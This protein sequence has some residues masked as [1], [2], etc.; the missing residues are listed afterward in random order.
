VG[1]VGFRSRFAKQAAPFLEPGEHIQAVFATGVRNDWGQVVYFPAFVVTDRAI[2]EIDR[3]LLTGRLTKVVKR[4]ARNIR[5]GP[6]SP[7]REFWLDH[8]KYQVPKACVKDVAAADAAL[9]EEVALDPQGPAGQPPQP[10]PPRQFS[11]HKYF[12]LNVGISLTL[13]FAVMTMLSPILDRHPSFERVIVAWMA[14]AVLATPLL[15]VA[16][17]A[18]RVIRGEAVRHRLQAQNR[19]R[20]GGAV[21]ESVTWQHHLLWAVLFIVGGF[22]AGVLIIMVGRAAGPH[23][24]V[25]AS[26]GMVLVWIVCAALGLYQIFSSVRTALRGRR[27]ARTPS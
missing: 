25:A 10:G 20:L 14:G 26:F 4:H 5:L 6:L 11:R 23:V 3:Q 13:F 22:M 18:F 9:A 8:L 2:I 27:A 17:L 24:F 15:V 21:V 16:W 19:Q 7:N 1:Q 12:L